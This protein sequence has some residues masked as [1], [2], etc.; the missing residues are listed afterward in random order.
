[1]PSGKAAR[2]RCATTRRPG[3][4]EI[5]ELEE[6]VGRAYSARYR[7]ELRA[8]LRDLPRDHG[9]RV[10]RAADRIDRLLLRAH[11]AAFAFAALVLRRRCGRSAAAA[12]SGRR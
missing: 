9:A 2:G 10:A 11:L 7:D 8:L 6:R 5:S 12:S 4:I 1:M 3:R